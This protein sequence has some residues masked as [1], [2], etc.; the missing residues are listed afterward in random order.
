M[1]S[2]DATEFTLVCSWME[3][4]QFPI[5]QKYHFL[6]IILSLSH[7]CLQFSAKLHVSAYAAIIR[8]MYMFLNY[9]TAVLVQI[10]IDVF[11]CCP[12]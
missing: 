8:L 11:R 7:T 5:R 10:Y 6:L 2:V 1:C 9:C 12:N 3:L 4:K